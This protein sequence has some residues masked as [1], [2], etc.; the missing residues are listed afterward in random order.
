[1]VIGTGT[2][3]TKLELKAVFG[4]IFQRFPALRLAVALEE[5]KLR[6][7]IVLAGSRSFRCSADVAD[8]AGN[9]DLLR[10]FA[11][12][13]GARRSDQPANR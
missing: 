9:R 7:A 8:A 5:L 3:P 11:G 10:N 6:K 12:G 4:S 13:H 2:A 1:M